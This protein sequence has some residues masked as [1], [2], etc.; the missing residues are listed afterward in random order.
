[1]DIDDIVSFVESKAMNT[2]RPHCIV[3]GALCTMMHKLKQILAKNPTTLRQAIDILSSWYL[4][5]SYRADLREFID[6]LPKEMRQTL[7]TL[8]DKAQAKADK[9]YHILFG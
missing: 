4:V 8:M 7:K 1:M 5:I 3:W 6:K 2:Y 9:A